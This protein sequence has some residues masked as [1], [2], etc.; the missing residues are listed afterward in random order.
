MADES[1][2]S[3]WYIGNHL[4]FLSRQGNPLPIGSALLEAASAIDL[5]DQSMLVVEWMKR[6]CVDAKLPECVYVHDVYWLN[7]EWL[8]RKMLVERSNMLGK[9]V[10]V[11]ELVR[12]PDEVE[13]GFTEFFKKQTTIP[14]T[15]GVVIKSKQSFIIGGTNGSKDNPMFVKVKWRE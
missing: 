14:Y 3:K 7:G 2:T 5:P 11:N 15:E 10:V 8:G 9:L 6:R 4:L 12:R 13:T 1:A